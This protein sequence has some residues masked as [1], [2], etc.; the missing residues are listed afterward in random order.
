MIFSRILSEITA[1]IGW[2]LVRSDVKLHFFDLAMEINGKLRLFII[3]GQMFF[4]CS[5]T[6]FFVHLK[7]FSLN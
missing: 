6:G 2:K 7:S 4:F 5:T 3:S 1:K